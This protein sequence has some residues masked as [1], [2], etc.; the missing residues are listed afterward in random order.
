MNFQAFNLRRFGAMVM[1]EFIQ[2]RRD[3]MTFSMMIGVPI[4][5]LMLFGYAINSNPKHLPTAVYSQDNGVFAR[6]IVWGMRNSSYFEIQRSAD[7]SNFEPVGTVTAKGNS[8]TT[9]TYQ[10]KDDLFLYI[11]NT[12]FY[13][14]KMVDV[15]GKFKYSSVVMIKL[16]VAATT[17][18]LKAWP[19]PFT[20]D[21]N[22]DYNSDTNQEIK[23]TM[24][25]INGAV[26]LNSSSIVKKGHNIITINQAQSKPS[27][28][29]LLTISNG[30]KSETI[31]V[32]KD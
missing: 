17:G 1:K 22:M 4:M 11:S 31:K 32:V 13:R 19:I 16:N 28:T 20:N 5:Q 7:G 8:A 15:G 23:I 24:R 2:M 18:T 27:G 29:Y 3:R 10:I 21:L 6:S 9:S 26:V 30:S 12:A 25:N 14:L